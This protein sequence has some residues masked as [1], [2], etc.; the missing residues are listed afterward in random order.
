MHVDAAKEAILSAITQCLGQQRLSIEKAHGR[1]LCTDIVSAFNVPPYINSAVDGYA[2]NSKDLPT[3][4]QTRKLNVCG[5]A[6]AGKPY[7][8]SIQSGDCIRIM[9]G[10][11]LPHSCDTVIMQEHC[12]QQGNCIFIDRQ[13]HAGQ[14]VRQAGEDILKGDTILSS[15]KYLTPA[16]IGLLASLGI[17]EV[18]VRRKI[19]VAIASTGD[20]LCNLGAIASDQQIFDSNRYMLLA[21]LDRADIEVIN[22]GILE[23]NPE[24]IQACF[25]STANHVDMIISTGGVSVGAA[26]HTKAALQACGNIDFWKVAI[27]PGRPL[28][29]GKIGETVFFGLPGNPVAVLVTFYLFVLPA[30]EALLGSKKK[31]IAPMFKAQT[32]QSIR[33]KPGR[34]EIQRGILQQQDNGDWQVKTTG[35]QGSGILRSMSLA[36]AFIVLEHDRS[37]IEAGEMVS[38]QPFA[39]L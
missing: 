13:H 5:T 26:D 38:V 10:A 7:P 3:T 18:D 31:P 14:N 25:S 9:T 11:Q 4:E 30:L 23:D 6:F 27:K 1:T 24:V 22:L 28:A 12:E 20:E 29:F 8:E 32:T 15:G 36:N 34:T 21:A 16:D 33:K 37:S 19:R 17:T 2:I 35:K 39:G